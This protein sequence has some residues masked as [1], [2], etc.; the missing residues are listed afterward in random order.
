MQSGPVCPDNTRRNSFCPDQSRNTLS[1]LLDKAQ[2]LFLPYWD[3]SRIMLP[4]K[5]PCKIVA[6]KIL[7]CS[8]IIIIYIQRK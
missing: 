1:H 5:V 7:N 3:T 6:D 4:L 8:F 2:K